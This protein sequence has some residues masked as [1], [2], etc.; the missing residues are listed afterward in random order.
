MQIAPT[1]DCVLLS[2]L[3][4]AVGIA[5][6]VVQIL[7]G[8]DTLTGATELLNAVPLAA[9]RPRPDVQSATH[10]RRGLNEHEH[11]LTPRSRTPSPGFLVGSCSW[12]SVSAVP[13]G[14]SS[15]P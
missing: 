15:S 3:L 13:A 12:T 8:G 9:T 2:V 6:A 1:T 4:A 14:I 10:E 11:T 5:V 7:S